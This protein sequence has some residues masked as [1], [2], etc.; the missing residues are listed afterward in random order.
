MASFSED[1]VL[2]IDLASNSS[3]SDSEEID[4]TSEFS[5]ENIETESF[6]SNDVIDLESSDSD[7]NPTDVESND[8]ED[9]LQAVV[10]PDLF[11]GLA[12]MGNPEEELSGQMNVELS[13]ECQ[14]MDARVEKFLFEF[15]AKCN[16]V[17]VTEMTA[18]QVST[19]MKT[20]YHV[21][22]MSPTSLMR[23]YWY[24]F[25]RVYKKHC[26]GLA[27]RT[28]LPDASD[29]VQNF[30]QW[31]KTQPKHGQSTSSFDV[32]KQPLMRFDVQR[33][34]S[35]M[36]IDWHNREEELSVLY[37]AI[38]TGARSC[39]ITNILLGDISS[40]TFWPLGEEEIENA[41]VCIRQRVQKGDGNSNHQHTLVGHSR[42]IF[43]LRQHLRKNFS[44]ELM[45]FNNWNLTPEQK[46]RKLW[47][48]QGKSLNKMLQRRAAAAGYP[49]TFFSFHSTRSGFLCQYILDGLRNNK[50]IHHSMLDCGRIA[51]WSSSTQLISKTQE[52]YFLQKA[53]NV[54]IDTAQIGI[55][56]VD[57]ARMNPESFHGI[58]LAT[59]TWSNFMSSG[60]FRRD[61]FELVETRYPGQYFA[62][63]KDMLFQK[64]KSNFVED[65]GR[66]YDDPIKIILVNAHEDVDWE[67]FDLEER[68]KE[69]YVSRYPDVPQRRWPQLRFN[70]R[71]RIFT[72]EVRVNPGLTTVEFLL[73]HCLH[74]Y[75]PESTR[76]LGE[77][78]PQQPAAGAPKQRVKWTQPEVDY[79]RANQGTKRWCDIA[80][81]LTFLF[82][83]YRNGQHVRDKARNLRK[84]DE[85]L[86][87]QAAA[88]EAVLEA[89][90]LRRTVNNESGPVQWSDEEVNYLLDS[91]EKLYTVVQMSQELGRSETEISVKL[92]SLSKELLN[93]A[94]EAAD[95]YH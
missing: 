28:R 74:G 76:H 16:I 89:R 19:L 33:I 10:I 47:H 26:N 24:S 50:S 17:A 81:E 45:D 40:L 57:E 22:N 71:C 3:S 58:T 34:E 64:A 72:E 4:L 30:F 7:Y 85:K 54:I 56:R 69:H 79:L 14:R 77:Q 67:T 55:P 94:A 48:W 84:A 18:E 62:H 80:S 59:T 65:T 13:N 8:D 95:F 35:V 66:T 25:N 31:L 38:E 36:P 23:P 87:A 2:V 5:T 9:V 39:T 60:H 88:A 44:L 75:E 92:R 90:D 61:F 6:N 1:S 46:Q 93:T 82:G 68:A 11:E 29:L 42:A 86:Q 83:N 63:E 32:S 78:H 49:E 73:D 52:K 53:K 12:L 37:Y 41:Q 91:M 20:L 21:G 43:F 70:T 51:C 27:L 15:M